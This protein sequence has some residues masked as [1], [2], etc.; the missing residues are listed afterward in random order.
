RL[1]LYG[2]IFVRRNLRDFFESLALMLEAGVSMADALPVAVETV[3]DGDIRREMIR[4]QPRV[5]KGSSLAEAM[6]GIRYL[7][8]ERLRQF[9]RTGEASGELPQ[10]LSRHTRFETELINSSLEHLTLWLPRAVY[11]IVVIWMAYGVL[12]N[13]GILLQQLP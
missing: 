2:P 3:E 11:G 6:R 9:V 12:R 5:A 4:I 13:S 8:D 10:M 7:N 1:P